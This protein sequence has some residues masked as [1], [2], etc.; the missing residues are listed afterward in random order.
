M[1]VIEYVETAW[2]RGVLALYIILVF[3]QAGD[4]RSQGAATLMDAKVASSV[5]SRVS[6][7]Y[8]RRGIPSPW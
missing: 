1:P 6:V 7:G 8:P 5:C 2:E 4:W 3:F